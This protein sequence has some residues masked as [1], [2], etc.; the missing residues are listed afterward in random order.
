M[1]PRLAVAAG[2]PLALL[3]ALAGCTSTPEPP[4]PPAPHDPGVPAGQFRLVAFDSC[5]NGLALMKNAAKEYVGP[6]GFGGGAIPLAGGARAAAGAAEDSAAGSSSREKAPSYSGT[7]THEAGVDEPDLVKTDGRRIVTVQQGTVRVVDAA[8]RKL[9]GELDLATDG[10]DPV[11]WGEGSLLL[12]GDRALVLVRGGWHTAKDFARPAGLASARLMLLD[13]SGAPKKISEYEV[14][15]ELVDAR[16]VGDTARVVV[17]SSP[18]LDFPYR[19]H[20][21][22][23]QQVAAN[24]RVIDKATAEDWFPRYAVTTGGTTAKGVL[25]CE[26][27][28]RPATYSGTSMVTVLSFTLGADGLG[29]G[30]P[31]GVVADG[32]TVYSN[33]SSL[34]VANDQRWRVMGWLERTNGEPKPEDEVTEIYRFDIS[35]PGR[36][37]YVGSGSVRGWLINQYAMSEW[38]GH[39]RVATTS[40]R[41]WGEAPK[42]S[43]TVYVLRLAGDSMPEVGKV[44]GLGKG[45]RIYAVRFAGTTGYVVTFRQTDPLYTVDLA[46]PA[47]PRV[48]GELKITGYSAYLHPAEPGRVIGVGQEASERGR[49]QG[50]QVSL[51]DVSNLDSPARLA[52]HHVKSAHSEAEYDPHAFL[53]W[54]ED[55]LLVMPLSVW[56]R[57][58]GGN[59]ALVLRIG[60]TAISEV[61]TISHE[62]KVGQPGVGLIRRSLVIGD[63][64]WTV[65]DSGLM[66]TNM[67]T[68]DTQAWLSWS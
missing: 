45:E 24:K 27:Y 57:D 8:S 6:Y 66:A 16:Q 26:R 20:G 68:L 46:N 31:V 21:T 5:A 7:N 3:V 56:E 61:G 10:D 34:Y 63:D 59:G 44:A 38:D 30:D 43:S 40:G 47:K 67:S 52:Q 23:K 64:L 2:V 42:S 55:R 22:E 11:R 25:G 29:D 48:A 18:R 37:A 13:I 36:P 54:P 60:D 65:S 35:R 17:R 19:E 41:T 33:G 51:F 28:S 58:R 4:S 14:D 15:G 9:T 50:T 12:H 1:T 53:Y 32:D 62:S 39:L 49:T